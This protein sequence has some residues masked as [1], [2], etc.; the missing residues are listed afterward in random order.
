MNNREILTAN[1]RALMK[2]AGITSQAQLARLAGVSQTQISNMLSGR[3]SATIDMLER[4][5]TAFGCE[6]WLLLA[7]PIY[8]ENLNREDFEPLLHCYLRLAPGAQNA[9]WELIHQLYAA[10]NMNRLGERG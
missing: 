7:P 3:K 8:L 2:Q 4:L 6:R 9:V 5:A 10:N 1:L